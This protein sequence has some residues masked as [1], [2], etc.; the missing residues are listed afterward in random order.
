MFIILSA[1]K[2]EADRDKAERLIL[3]HEKLMYKIAW[4]IL[5][6]RKDA[7]DTVQ[8]T[9]VRVIKN[10]H[11]IDESDM[12]R[13]RNFFS[14][15]CENTAKNIYNKRKEQNENSYSYDELDK[16]IESIGSNP[17]SIIITNES[18]DEIRESILE[19]RRIYRVVIELRET[20]DCSSQ[21]ISEILNIPVETV[22]TR[23]KRARNMLSEKLLKEDVK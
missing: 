16:K 8:D 4:R 13:T 2:D 19:L 10:L 22:K 5:G 11:K 18:V 20:Y 1:I 15:I 6:D 21:E 9:I 12:L 23:L 7:E 3:K 17:L 14:I